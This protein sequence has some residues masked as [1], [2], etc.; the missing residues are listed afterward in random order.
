MICVLQFRHAKRAFPTVCFHDFLSKFS[1]E[2]QSDKYMQW[3]ASP[4]GILIANML[5]LNTKRASILI[6]LS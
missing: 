5:T 1:L 6:N 2:S 4:E 3:I